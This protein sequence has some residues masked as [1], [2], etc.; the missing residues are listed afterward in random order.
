MKLFNG[1][2]RS[3]RLS[4]ATPPET[5]SICKAA[6]A[7][8]ELSK[9]AK[10]TSLTKMRF[11]K[12]CQNT[13][14]EGQPPGSASPGQAAPVE[15]QFTPKLAASRM[16]NLRSPQLITLQCPPLPS[17]QM[18]LL[19]NSLESLTRVVSRCTSRGTPRI[20]KIRKLSSPL[21]R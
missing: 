2:R 15:H 5:V 20:F 10:A 9:T 6:K 17:T 7:P 13:R 19:S 4:V 3:S 18:P 16:P 12:S 1:F 11:K 8:Q 14:T 21:L